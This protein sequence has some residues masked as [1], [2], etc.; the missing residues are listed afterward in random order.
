MTDISKEA[1][2]RA[3]AWL[4]KGLS[5]HVEIA[6]MLRAL[7]AALDAAEAERDEYRQLFGIQWDADRRAVE[8]WRAANPGN[9]LVFPDSTRLAVW[10]LEQRDKALVERD[11]WIAHAKA[12]IWADSEECKALTEACERLAAERDAAEAR[13]VEVRVKPLVWEPEDNICTRFV[14]PALGGH[15]MI[16]ELDP[17]K[18]S[19]GID[20]GGLCFRFVQAM[21]D[22]GFGRPY[23]APAQWDTVEEAQAAAQS[24]HDARILS[25]VDVVGVD[26]AVQAE[27][28]I[29]TKAIETYFD[30][31]AVE[32]VERHAA[33]IRARRG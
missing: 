23:S 7:R 18:Y 1:V 28:A 8:E 27:R 29:W 14:A 4:D 30:A 2:E 21:K 3:A 6:S 22:D 20:L 15:M 19:A 11:Q 25:A 10:A 33:A 9:D 12:A 24:D 16:V 31:T 13:A 26:A 17:G 5:V 32:D